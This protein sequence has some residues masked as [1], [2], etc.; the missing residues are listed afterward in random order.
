MAAGEVARSD[1]LDPA[2]LVVDVA[3][4]DTGQHL[5]VAFERDLD[6]SCLDANNPSRTRG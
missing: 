5:R 2:T 6:N 1:G 4:R 3:F